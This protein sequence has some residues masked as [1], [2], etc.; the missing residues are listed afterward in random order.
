MAFKN[1][2]LFLDILLEGL[3]GEKKKGKSVWLPS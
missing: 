3:R 2:F 1:R